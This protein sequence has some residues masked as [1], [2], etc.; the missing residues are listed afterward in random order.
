MAQL[1][2]EVD[3]APGFNYPGLLQTWHLIY[4][5]P[6]LC[7]CPRRPINV[8]TPCKITIAFPRSRLS[9]WTHV[10][11]T[12][13]ISIMNWT[14]SKWT[15]LRNVPNRTGS[16][17]TQNRPIASVFQSSTIRNT[18]VELQTKHN[19]TQAES[20]GYWLLSIV[21]RSDVP[22]DSASEPPKAQNRLLERL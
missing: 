8:T 6:P 9:W 3:S 5:N 16:S 18:C 15:E 11:D 1:K 12:D 10:H 20:Q 22:R 7:G 14:Q 17:G 13:I 4:G 2:I 21:T 19:W